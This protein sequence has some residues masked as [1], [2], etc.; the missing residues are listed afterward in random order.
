MIQRAL[1]LIVLL[2]FLCALVHGADLDPA[3]FEA[4]VV[5]DSRV[6]IVEFYSAM[7]GGCQEFASTWD[8]I[9]EAFSE[10]SHGGAIAT[11]KIN[12]DN[13]A[14]LKIAEELGV[15]EDGVPHVRLFKRKGDKKG[16]IM[17]KSKFCYVN[18]V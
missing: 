15:L 18:K 17:V 7:C 9:A 8:R 10:S 5:N 4:T 1:M 12:I 16:M 2:V 3:T 6:W 14:G 13:K 11:G